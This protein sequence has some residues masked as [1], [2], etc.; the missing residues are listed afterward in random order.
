MQQ[1]AQ[2]KRGRIET[3]ILLPLCDKKHDYTC[4]PCLIHGHLNAQLTM[5]ELAVSMETRL[6]SA[7]SLAQPNSL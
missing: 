6:E 4:T 7:V 5:M 2:I 1:Q 3:G